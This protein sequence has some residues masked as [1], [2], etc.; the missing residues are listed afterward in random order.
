[1]REKDVVWMEKLVEGVEVQQY[2]GLEDWQNEDEKKENKCWQA[3]VQLELEEKWL[4]D[5]EIEYYYF[6]YKDHFVGKEKVVDEK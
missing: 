6:V 2:L 4:N 5:G 1:M 3:L